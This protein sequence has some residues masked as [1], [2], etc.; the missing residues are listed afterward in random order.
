MVRALIA[1]ILGGVLVFFAG[2]LGHTKLN[3]TEGAIQSH[4]AHEDAVSAAL[5]NG[6][7]PGFYFVPGKDMSKTMTPEEEKK[8]DEAWMAKY[9]AGPNAVIL[10]G[11]DGE[12]FDLTRHL[13]FEGVSD[14]I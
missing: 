5:K 7:Q 9:K 8:S 1:G 6:S 11:P 4:I 2:F 3:L 14:I 12:D 13:I 10:R